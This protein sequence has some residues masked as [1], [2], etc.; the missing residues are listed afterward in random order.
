MLSVIPR[1]AA[2]FGLQASFSEAKT[3]HGW[4]VLRFLYPTCCNQLCFEGWLFVGNVATPIVWYFCANAG[5]NWSALWLAKQQFEG[6]SWLVF[7][8]NTVGMW[9]TTPV[10]AWVFRILSRQTNMPTLLLFQSSKFSWAWIA[11][12][13]YIQF[14]QVQVP[15]KRIGRKAFPG[16]QSSQRNSC[17][18]KLILSVFVNLVL[19]LLASD[20]VN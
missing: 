19:V 5:F 20:F 2:P 3:G 10:F 18:R 4:S 13:N 7:Y 16:R 11:L 17:Q 1:R 12:T 14:C 9:L 6:S 15:M 8:G